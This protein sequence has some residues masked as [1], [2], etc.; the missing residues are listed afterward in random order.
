MS[1]INSLISIYKNKGIVI[2][3]NLWL[4]LL[5]GSYNKNKISEFKRTQ[6]YTEEDFKQLNTF[7]QN[8]KI[9]TTPNIL[10]EVVN[11]TETL[12]KQSDGILFYN[13]IQLVQISHEIFLPSVNVMDN[14]FM[15]FG[16]TD[17]VIHSLAA[18]GYLI[19]TDDFPLFG[20]LSS[21][22]NAV[23]NFNHIRTEYIFKK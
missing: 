8:F 20:Y 19:L 18:E 14:V 22:G 3:A 16:L 12:D 21:R 17:S 2:D 7:L 1:F 13:L 23:I 4:L 9:I 11:L 5:V 15:K 10:T 6:K